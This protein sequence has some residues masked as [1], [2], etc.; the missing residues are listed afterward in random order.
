M[1]FQ[2]HC[3]SCLPSRLCYWHSSSCII[4]SMSAFE[5]THKYLYCIISNT[6]QQQPRRCDIF[7]Y[8]SVWFSHLQFHTVSTC[9]VQSVHPTS[10][11]KSQKEF[12]TTVQ[13]TPNSWEGMACSLCTDSPS[14]LC[15]VYH[16]SQIYFIFVSAAHAEAMSNIMI[17][18]K[19]DGWVLF[20]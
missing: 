14:L 3:R 7:F 5:C 6:V 17:L 10:G 13:R 18:L 1:I 12:Q 15:Y 16:L 8:R 20:C 2:V 11:S 4:F 9:M 19:Q